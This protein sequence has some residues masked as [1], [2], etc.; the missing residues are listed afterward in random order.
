MMVGYGFAMD[1]TAEQTR[2]AC[3]LVSV[4]GFTV[5]PD[6]ANAGTGAAMAIAGTA[7]AIALV[8]VR[9][10]MPSDVL[11]LSTMVELPRISVAGRRPGPIPAAM[12]PRHSA[13]RSE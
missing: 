13:T 8:T 2:V 1:Q 4:P 7:Q 3:N 5:S 11:A 12:S 10:L 9:R 6:A